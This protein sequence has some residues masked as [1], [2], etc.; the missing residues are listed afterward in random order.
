MVT[1][2]GGDLFGLRGRVLLALETK[3][4]VARHSRAMTVVSSAMRTEAAQLGLNPPR[5]EVLPM[6]VD[7]QERFIVDAGTAR[8]S[9]QI[10]FVGR[11]VPKKGLCHLLDAMPGILARRPDAKLDIAGFGPERHAL[12]SQAKR[13]G[14]DHRVNFLGA[15]QQQQLPALYRRASV[16]VAP[17]IRDE[18]GNQEGLPVVL[19]EAIGCGCPVIVGDVAGVQD[20]LGEARH[21]VSVR[22]GD[23]EALTSAVVGVLEDPVRAQDRAATIRS[24]AANHVDWERIAAGYASLIDDCLLQAR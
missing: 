8:A 17:F 18:S 19:M 20:L 15:M 10:L 1:S 12:E 24:A 2:H 11:L 7:L 16:F 14:I 9:D 5:L 4:L 13:L 6:G 3:T 21:D 23:V 22:P